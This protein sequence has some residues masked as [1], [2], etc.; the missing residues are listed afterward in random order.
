MTYSAQPSDEVVVEG[1]G[2][3]SGR[4]VLKQRAMRVADLSEQ[5][6]EAGLLDDACEPRKRLQQFGPV[7][8]ALEQQ[9]AAEQERLH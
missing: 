7:A 3:L 9:I 5:A 4:A 8:A 2:D 1:A 6:A